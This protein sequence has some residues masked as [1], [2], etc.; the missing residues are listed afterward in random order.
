MAVGFFYPGDVND[1]IEASL[2]NA[3]VTKQYGTT[4]MFLNYQIHGGVTFRLKRMDFS[5]ELAF[6]VCSKMDIG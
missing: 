5:G 2:A 4:D 1:Y 6:A 3:G